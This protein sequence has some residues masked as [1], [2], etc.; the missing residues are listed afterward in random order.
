ME[1]LANIRMK[2]FLLSLTLAFLSVFPSFSLD[3]V[4]F[5]QLNQKARELR[6]QQDW[7]ALREVL[8]EIG[9][10]LPGA[11]PPYRLRM[12]LVEMHLD[13]KTEALQWLQKFAAT[14]LA[15]DVAGDNDLE[16][17]SGEHNFQEHANEMN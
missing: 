12:A 17:L 3:R 16:S 8:L 11:T 14:G 7:K 13:H 15:Y 1:I 4:H 6:K 5:D 9:R 2:R 10:E